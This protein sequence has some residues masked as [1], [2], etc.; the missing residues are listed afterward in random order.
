[1]KTGSKMEIGDDGERESE[2]LWAKTETGL[3]KPLLVV[4]VFPLPFYQKPLKI[5]LFNALAEQLGFG[6][7]D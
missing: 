6:F 1:M 2:T 7:F 4:S 5:V 3:S